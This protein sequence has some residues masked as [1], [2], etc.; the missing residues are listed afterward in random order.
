VLLAS[1]AT[2]VVITTLAHA[3]F[4]GVQGYALGRAKFY[5][6]MAPRARNLLLLTALLAAATLNGLFTLLGRVV[7]R[8]DLEVHPWRGLAWAAGFAALVFFAVSLLMRRHLEASLEKDP[9]R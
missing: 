6:S 8:T 5:K 1:G 4:A 3:C 9:T 2:Q 7:R